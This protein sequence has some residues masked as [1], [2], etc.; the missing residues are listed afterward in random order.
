MMRTRRQFLHAVSAVASLSGA[1]A[2]KSGSDSPQFLVA[3]L[4][5]LDKRG[6]FDD[7]LNRDYLAYL[8]AGGAGGALA[9][10]TTGEF[11]SFS[12]AE[13]KQ[14]LESFLRHKGKLS[15]MAQIGTPNLPETLDLLDHAT[16]A[17]AGSVLVLPPF[18]FKNPSV[19]GLA[20]FF[21]PILTAAKLP[22][23]L[24]NIPQLSGVPITAELLR[25]LSRHER[26]AGIKDSFSK[27][28][29]LVAFIREFPKL[30]II[31]GV[32]RNLTVDLR[33]GGAG[34]ISGNASVFL[35]ETAAVFEAYRKGA[36]P[37]PAQALLDTAGA[38]LS[39]YDGIPAMKYALSR[40]GL[41]E[42]GYRPPFI[43]LPAQK[44]QDLAARLKV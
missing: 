44:K 21:E 32:P 31:T 34:I 19:E 29:A 6:R 5:M 9:L 11:S 41:R 22:V 33:E 40:M 27:A 36:D 28:D 8:A 13:R 18:Y 15:V 3:A 25:I 24:Y 12:V 37:Q 17:G 7:G 42:S 43:E 26:L 2:A 16:R 1:R 39:G 10:G 14:I 4:T 23:Y 30:R 20:A 35:R 38:A